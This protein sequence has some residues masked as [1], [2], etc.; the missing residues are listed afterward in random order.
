MEKYAG[1]KKPIKL[2]RKPAKML[3]KTNRVNN[4]KA[5]IAPYAFA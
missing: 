5:P 3:K 1:K 2:V 4:A